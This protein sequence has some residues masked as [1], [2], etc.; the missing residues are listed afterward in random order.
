MA[1]ERSAFRIAELGCLGCVVL[2]LE[3]GNWTLQIDLWTA[4]WSPRYQDEV[5]DMRTEID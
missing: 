4:V 1:K 3:V 2:G 5:W